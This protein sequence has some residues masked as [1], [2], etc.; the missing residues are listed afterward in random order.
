[1]LPLRLSSQKLMTSTIVLL[2]NLVQ[3]WNQIVDFMLRPSIWN[4]Q[5]LLVLI[6][7]IYVLTESLWRII[8]IDIIENKPFVYILVLDDQISSFLERTI[9][10]SW[11]CNSD[12]CG[13]T[14]KFKNNVRSHVESKHILSPGFNCQICSQFCKDRKSLRNHIYFQHKNKN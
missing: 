6:V 12:D 8:F 13:Y 14:S 9:D 11:K 10:G 1:M 3:R 5:E 2:V 7:I 4:P